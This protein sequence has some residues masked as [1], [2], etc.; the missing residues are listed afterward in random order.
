MPK[1]YTTCEKCGVT[2]PSSKKH[3]CA[4]RDVFG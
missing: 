3:K 2:H 4:K 1:G